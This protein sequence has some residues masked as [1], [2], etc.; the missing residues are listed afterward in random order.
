MKNS[1]KV[2]MSRAVRL[3]TIFSC[4]ILLLCMGIVFDSSSTASLSVKVIYFLIPFIILISLWSYRIK[5]Y[6]LD[7]DR[8]II[9]RSF[10]SEEILLDNLNSVSKPHIQF[11]K[12][13]KQVGNS[14]IFSFT[15]SFAYEGIGEF[16][17]YV[18][19]WER[20]ILVKMSHRQVV[21]SPYNY[22][23]F[24]EQISQYQR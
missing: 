15:G 9:E 19:D 21:V 10:K 16:E 4:S 7:E 17:S 13:K 18:T 14:G 24:L 3:I 23:A 6:I 5:S 8:L 12:L 11:K 1:Y 20:A 22:E 2:K